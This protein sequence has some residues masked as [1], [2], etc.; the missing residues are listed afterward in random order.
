MLINP[1][2]RKTA[3]RAIEAVQTAAGP[4]ALTVQ[5]VEVLGPRGFE[6]AFAQI[7]PNE[8][9]GVITVLDPMFFNERKQMAEV[10]LARRLPTM[11]T[12][13]AYVKEGALM[14]YAPNYLDI[15]RRVGIYVDKIINGSKPRDL[16]VQQPV[17]YDVTINLKTARTLGVSVTPSILAESDEVIE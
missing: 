17:K 15:M 8:T 13:D 16:P 7:A 4:L 5:P 2:N 6:K 12:G 14:S 10:A 3:Q 11:T 1:D 9:A